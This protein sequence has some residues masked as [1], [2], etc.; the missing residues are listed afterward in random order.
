MMNMNIRVECYAGYRADEVPQRFFIGEKAI[1]IVDVLDRWL[2]PGH[3]Y[4][5]VRGD[6][7]GIYIN[8]YYRCRARRS[9]AEYVSGWFRCLAFLF[10]TPIA[11]QLLAEVR[12]T[13]NPMADRTSCR[14]DGPDSLWRG[15]RP[16]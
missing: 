8:Q 7:Q 4:F 5:K 16:P 6:D 3:H 15:R 1:D 2:D 14:H 10:P 9:K 12:P 11:A 13:A